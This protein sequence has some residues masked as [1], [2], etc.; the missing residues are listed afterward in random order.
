[1]EPYAFSEQDLKQMEDWGLTSAEVNRQ[2]EIFNRPASFLKLTAPCTVEDGIRTF[3]REKR[4]TLAAVYESKGPG[5]DCVKFVPA[6]GAAS[7]MFKVL[8]RYFH[9]DGEITRSMVAG[10]AAAGSPDAEQFLIFAD[11]LKRF[12]FFRDL[13]SVMEDHNLRVDALLKEGRFRDILGFLLTD[14]G[15]D[16]ADLPKG[17]LKFHEYPTGSRTAF[18]EHL[19]EAA[20]Y[21]TRRDGRCVLG[22]TVSPEHMDRFNATLQEAKG[23]YEEKFKVQYAV[24]FSVQDPSTDTIAVDLDNAPF[25]QEDGS[26]L[27]RPGGHGA[28]LR[29]LHLID[30][31][32]IFIKNID[33]VVPDH[34]KPETSLWKKITAGYLLEM[35]GR[36]FGFM[37]KL[38]SGNTDPR[39][40]DQ[41]ADFLEKELLISV[42]GHMKQGP[43]EERRAYL[44]ERLDRPIRVCGMVRNV[45]EPGGGPFWV[46][47]GSGQ[48]SIQ[49][50]ET[51]Q[52]DFDSA[53]QREIF[54]AS[55]HFNPVD[56]VCGVKDWQG[57]PFD[58]TRFVDPDAVFISRKFK[59]GKDLKALEHPGLWNGSMSG[60]I[61]QLVEVPDITF[62]PV[63]TVN[64]L[65]RKGHQPAG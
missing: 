7:R 38:A 23:V 6:S 22:F 59:D 36:I 39:L 61:T 41:A 63:K 21:V 64:D 30:G 29:N 60:W 53:Q 33:N 27:F 14:K 1:M 47:D 35:Q 57:R 42:P 19:V 50:V 31:E 48:R 55:T 15:L 10:E 2:L 8:L 4:D 17:L 37:E 58:L 32:I 49:I 46:E 3:D 18:E 25:R 40:L 24:S 56:L 54:D 13:Q 44:A 12:A 43:P 28:L 9:R 16:Y 11:G 45:G 5:R 20:S 34:L 65:L 62:N 51:A 26:L 52:I